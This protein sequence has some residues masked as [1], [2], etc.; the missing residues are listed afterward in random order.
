MI[1]IRKSL[2]ETNSSSTHAIC[3]AREGGEFAIPD[4]LEFKAGEFGWDEGFLYTPEEKASYLYTAILC[5][6][7]YDADR[8]ELEKAKN[9]IYEILGNHGC[10]ATFVEPVKTLWGYDF[11]IDHVSDG[12]YTFVDKVLKSEKAL[13][14][15]LFS[16]DSFIAT[17]NDN[18]DWFREW[19]DDFDD[20]EANDKVD[21][22]Y[23]GN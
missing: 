23:K 10:D 19:E 9:H 7:I 6:H 12:T 13:L 4:E 5:R 16:P 1:N 22:Y 14:R 8:K 21:V 15:Y 3:I 17:G 11:Y 18:S 20:S 2:F